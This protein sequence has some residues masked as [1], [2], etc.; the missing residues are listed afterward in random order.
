VPDIR[1]VCKMIDGVHVITAP[2]EIDVTTADELG[3]ALV[4]AAAG[5]HAVVVVDMTGT[6]FCDS[7][8]LSVLAGAHRKALDEGG[9]LRLV[10]PAGGSVVRILTLTGVGRFIPSFGSLEEALAEGLPL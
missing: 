7:A 2:A 10:M 9:E 3:T 5:G 6:S 8:G 4:G 1:Y